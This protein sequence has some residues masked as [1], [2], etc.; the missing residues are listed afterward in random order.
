[1]REKNKKWHPKG[2]SEEEG[3]SERKRLC[4]LPDALMYFHGPCE[5]YRKQV[6][7]MIPETLHD[8]VELGRKGVML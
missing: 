2:L 3:R 6:A 7:V 8:S 1:M 4:S 5:C